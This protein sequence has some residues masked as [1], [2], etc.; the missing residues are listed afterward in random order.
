MHVLVLAEHDGT[1]LRAG[2]A[3]ALGFALDLA[4]H[5]N[6][7]VTCLVLG[8]HVDGVAQAAAAY[9]DVLLGDHA[10]L[11]EPL[12]ERW[13]EV[14]AGV[15][16]SEAA[17]I[18]LG[19]SSTFAR[20]VL[21]R[22]GGLLGGAMA[23]DVTGF[24]RDEGRWVWQRPMY[25]GAVTASVVLCGSPLVVTVRPT[26]AQAPPHRPQPG[27]ITPVEID[28]EELPGSTTYLGLDSRASHRPDVTEAR[29][30]VSGGR[31]VKTT[32][33]FERLVGGLADVFDGA[34]GSSR[35][36]VD[37]GLTPNDLQV[38]QTGKVVAPELYIAVGISG[39]VQHLAGMKNSRTIV[40]I[41]S[42]PHAPIFEVADYGIVGDLYDIVPEMIQQL[43]AD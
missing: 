8:E 16:R 30:V 39:A 24:R 34:T 42:D 33:D 7:T 4:G 21:G 17:D 2:T 36:L 20:D 22:A 13:A 6:G 37:A 43:D 28:A 38:G 23:S 40:A 19:A 18:L 10:V 15:V 25:A 12:A 32:D 29:V 3:A 14:T 9:G 26:A 27:S 1:R 11:A 5:D 31:G 35:A 41:N